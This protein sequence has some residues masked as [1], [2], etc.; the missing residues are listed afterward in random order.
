VIGG[1][2]AR[3]GD[4]RPDYEGQYFFADFSMGRIYRMVLD[5]QGRPVWTEVWATDV[6]GP[7]ELR[8]G[9]DGALYYLANGIGELRRIAWLADGASAAASRSR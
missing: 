6:P 9:P 7:V 8:F 2:H 4:L 5:A 1:D 3:R